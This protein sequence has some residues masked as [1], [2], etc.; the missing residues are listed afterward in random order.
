MLPRRISR[1]AFLIG[2]AS[3][4]ATIAG[5]NVR[6]QTRQLRD[7]IQDLFRPSLKVSGL[8]SLDQADTFDVCIIGSGPA[9]AVLGKDLVDH[10]LRTVILESGP[11]LQAAADERLKGLEVYHNTGE[12]EYPIAASRVRG[13][14]GTSNIWTG[15]CSRLHPLDFER[16]AYTPADAQWPITYA[17]L[18]PYYDRAETTLRVHGDTLSQYHA[19]RKRGLPLPSQSDLTALKEL[20]QGIGITVDD[21]PTSTGIRSEDGPIRV[22]ADLLP[23]FTDSRNALLVSG[24]TATRL[25]V[26]PDGQIDGVEVQNLDREA[27]VVKARAYVVA[28]GAL[29]SARLLLLSRSAAFPNGIGNNHDQVGRYFMEHPN[30]ILTGTIPGLKSPPFNQVGRSHQFYDEFKQ[31]GFGS[32]ILI[33]YWNPSRP[34]KFRVGATLEMRPLAENRVTLARD[35]VDYYGNPAAELSLG[36]SPDDVSALDHTRSVI[37][38]IFARLGAEE[39]EEG[40]ISWSHHHMGTCRM[41]DDPLTS[42]VDRNLRVHDVPNLYVAGSAAFV[43]GGAAHPTLAITALCHRLADHLVARLGGTAEMIRGPEFEYR[44]AG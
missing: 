13:L 20:M 30:I 12:I 42:V 3:A 17:D 9:G 22:A 25:I 16:N 34:E 21:S 18:E 31:Q 35:L 8:N 10:G 40:E 27:R 5:C 36:F 11:N 29:E 6:N 26:G 41:G 23:L 39:I 15:R 44:A 7:Q 38:D 32:A 28:C 19:P 4:A 1:R 43:T 24:V 14:G 33:F 37:R 2:V